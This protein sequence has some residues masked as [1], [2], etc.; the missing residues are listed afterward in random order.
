LKGLPFA[1]ALP[2]GGKREVE[3]QPGFVYYGINIYHLHLNGN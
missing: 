2:T 3:L 1:R